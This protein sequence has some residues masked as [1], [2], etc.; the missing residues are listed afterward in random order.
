MSDNRIDNR[1][2]D[3]AYF[4][5]LVTAATASLVGD[6]VLLANVA[7][8]RTDFIRLNNGDVR[9]A[10]SVDQRTLT[11]DLIEGRR[12]VGGR[13]RLSGVQRIDSARLTAL[14]VQLRDQRRLVADDPF[15]LYN[16]EPTSTQR[17]ERGSIP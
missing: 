1:V 15:L 5:E 3:Q 17:I 13:I 11:V 4:D 9:Q 6:E 2:D 12:H 8:E 10:G 16:T 14:L 7:G